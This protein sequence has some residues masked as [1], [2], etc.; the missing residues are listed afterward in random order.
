MLE[1]CVFTND[2]IRVI[3]TDSSRKAMTELWEEQ[4]IPSSSVDDITDA[5]ALGIPE[6]STILAPIASVV[7]IV[8]NRT[9]KAKSN[10]H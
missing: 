3:S 9:R 7:L 8:G 4:N 5:V 2:K 1:I 6:F 10:Q